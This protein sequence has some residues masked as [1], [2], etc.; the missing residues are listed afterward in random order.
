MRF[1]K[2]ILALLLVA[3]MAVSSFEGIGIQAKEIKLAVPVI[4]V[5]TV[6]NGTGVKVTIKKTKDAEGFEVYASGTPDSYVGYKEYRCSLAEFA[7]LNYNGS[8]VAE[9]EKN[10]KAK[11]TVTIK[12]LPPGSYKIKVRSYNS[13]KYGTMT[14]SDFSKEK[15]VKLKEASKGYS[16][17]YDF[18]KVKKGDVIKFGTYEQDGDFTNG[19]EA[20][21]WIVL[22]K[23]EGQIFVVSK[24]VLD[25]LPYNK[26]RESVTWEDCTLREWLNEKFYANAFNKSEK[27]MIKATIVEN[28]D[29]AVHG[30]VGGKDTKDKVFLL[31]QLDVI[32][33]D[34]GFADD[35]DT[36]DEYRR[37]AATAYAKVQIP[38]V[39]S[40]KYTS[41]LEEPC[42]WWLRS[43]GASA[44]KTVVVFSSGNVYSEGLANFM[45]N[46]DGVRP[47]LVIALQS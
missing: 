40:G 24:Y 30:T 1:A 35:Y 39:R 8:K 7:I 14:Y 13:K 3:G 22:Y 17:S 33:T 34:Y 18:S 28:H 2:K 26:E 38:A 4:S 47:A 27:R 42:D 23:T 46:F 25:G 45:Y 5:K 31:S 6:K 11:R 32:N 43:P 9:I 16:L 20:I 12:T 19:K 44:Y 41:D 29:N 21:E 37:C 10:G 36:Y 15:S